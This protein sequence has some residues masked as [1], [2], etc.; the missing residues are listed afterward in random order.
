MSCVAEPGCV[1][2]VLE[3]DGALQGERLAE[4]AVYR[5]RCDPESGA[6]LVGSETLVCDGQSYNDSTPVCVSGPTTLTVTG[7]ETLEVGQAGTF[8]C[9]S[10]EVSR[11]GRLHWSL[12]DSRGGEVEAAVISEEL[13]SVLPAGSGQVAQSSLSLSLSRPVRS[14]VVVVECLALSQGFTAS[15]DLRVDIHCK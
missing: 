12:T 9:R 10:D 8:T 14:S 7:P 11:P 15:A 13:S 6:R 1:E 5:L 4:G 2:P 3:A